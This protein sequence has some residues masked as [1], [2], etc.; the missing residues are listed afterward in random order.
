MAPGKFHVFNQ[1]V[2]K[3]LTDNPKIP[4]STWGANPGLL[5]SY[6][7][8]SDKYD[9]VYHQASYG[10]V[11]DIAER[12][13]LQKQLVNY[14]DEIAADLE[15]EAVR[16]PEMLLSSGFDLAK[17]RRGNTRK[18]AALAGAEVTSAEHHGSTS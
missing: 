18:K 14:L 9:A 15:A 7:S 10:S 5:T 6:L 1:R 12:E 17:E 16:N 11:L 2:S 3:D 8:A 4:E 13:L